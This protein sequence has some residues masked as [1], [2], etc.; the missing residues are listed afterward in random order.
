VPMCGAKKVV[1]S[2]CVGYM[3]SLVCT[4]LQRTRIL[5]NLVVVRDIIGA[6]GALDF[7]SLDNEVRIVRVLHYF[8]TLES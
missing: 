7:Y 3:H 6:D 5:R 4:Y 8:S 1:W 2:N